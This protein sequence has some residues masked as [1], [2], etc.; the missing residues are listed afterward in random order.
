[1]FGRC[2]SQSFA[3]LHDLTEDHKKVITA[4]CSKVK[5][6]AFF[7][8]DSDPFISG[9]SI[10]NQMEDEVMIKVE[11]SSGS[12]DEL[13]TGAKDVKTTENVADS[14]CSNSEDDELWE[15]QKVMTLSELTDG[16]RYIKC[17]NKKCKL[18]AAVVYCNVNS[19]NEYWNACLDCQVRCLSPKTISLYLFF[20][21]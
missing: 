11:D 18:A 16:R 7:S 2:P 17:S 19:P 12:A 3:C 8:M 4:K 5:D 6:V 9:S 10:A 20:I 13:S 21:I 1:M 15:I 14:N